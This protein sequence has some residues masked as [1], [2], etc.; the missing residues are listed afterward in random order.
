MAVTYAVSTKSFEQVGDNPPRQKTIKQ[1]ISISGTGLFTAEKATLTLHPADPG[2][3][4]W[5]RRSDLPGAPKL[6]AHLQNVVS[7]PRCTILG[8]EDF[9]V[10]TV[11]HILAALAALGINNAILDL[12]GPEVPIMDGSSRI[13][14]SAIEE[15]GILEQEEQKQV[16]TLSSPLYWSQ[17]DIHLV[18]IPSEEYRI[19]YTL[20]F[21][22][23]EILHAQFF[24]SVISPENFARDIAPCR[25]FCVYEEILPF[26]ESGLI[27]GGGLENAIIIKNNKVINPGGVRFSDEMVR[28]KILD[29]IGDLSLIPIGFQAHIIAIRSGH[30]SNIAFAADLYKHI[31]MEML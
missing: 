15:G 31:Q 10:H 5:F 7:T 20:H 6:R 24:S 23:S 13:F 21:P 17:G 19:S 22:D 28:H 11:E 4:I 29:L 18:A 16:H 1:S 12:T 27:K 2:A 25:T 30:A 14:V 3:G 8:K 26:I 9:T